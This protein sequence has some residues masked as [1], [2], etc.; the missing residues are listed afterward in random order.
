MTD[1]KR[2]TNEIEYWARVEEICD[3]CG[4]EDPDLAGDCATPLLS[5]NYITTSLPRA[6]THHASVGSSLELTTGNSPS[7]FFKSKFVFQRTQ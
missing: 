5:P 4:V 1:F 2:A 6:M 7:F 3:F